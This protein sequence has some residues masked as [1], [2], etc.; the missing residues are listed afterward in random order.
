MNRAEFIL[1][2]NPEGLVA[3]FQIQKRLVR[4]AEAE[5]RKFMNAAKTMDA[6]TVKGGKERAS[7]YIK[8]KRLLEDMTR[9]IKEMNR[10]QQKGKDT[11]G[12]GDHPMELGVKAGRRYREV[13]NQVAYGLGDILSVQ[14]GL[15]EMIR[16]S[17]NNI[18]YMAAQIPGAAGRWAMF[19][20][21]AA[22]AIGMVAAKTID[23]RDRQ[24]EA[25]EAAK[26]GQKAWAGLV[27]EIERLSATEEQR[28]MEAKR[29]E[30]AAQANKLIIAKDK[31][32]E[33]LEP[34]IR[35]DV[36]I[37]T[38]LHARTMEQ[39]IDAAMGALSAV[40]RG[41]G[42][43][44]IAALTLGAVPKTFDTPEERLRERTAD[45]LAR[46]QESEA[47]S[48]M[49]DTAMKLFEQ[50]MAEKKAEKVVEKTRPDLEA[51]YLDMIKRGRPEKEAKA[52]LTQMIEDGLETGAKAGAP[53]VAEAIAREFSMSGA[54]QRFRDTLAAS[55]PSFATSLSLKEQLRAASEAVNTAKAAAMQ[56]KVIESAEKQTIKQL[57]MEENRIE[58][59]IKALDANT[60]ATN[61]SSRRDVIKAEQGSPILPPLDPGGNN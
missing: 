31:A 46:K 32:R 39:Q 18:Q 40:T 16:A 25:N 8:E 4:E 12:R 56:D 34:L 27:G 13:A 60:K 48:K 24:K 9:A 42:N 38:P 58:A 20:A 49:R 54:S 5:L 37:H 19:G 41:M 11:I 61:E 14:G 29:R 47:A 50:S 52:I 33:A 44:G 7:I 57:E 26:E 30:L 2:G 15:A 21:V 53:K 22:Q 36:A 51:K 1:D 28:D 23:L 10:E 6:E 35:R 43:L 3:A 45:Y 17:A 59:L 55:D